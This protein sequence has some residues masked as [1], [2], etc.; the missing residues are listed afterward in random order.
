[1][2]PASGRVDWAAVIPPVPGWTA[3][4]QAIRV[5]AARPADVEIGDVV[6][7]TIN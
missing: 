3:R 7:L 5:P 6:T 1:M 4:F 2:I